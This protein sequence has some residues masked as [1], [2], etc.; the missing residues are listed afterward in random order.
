MVTFTL[1]GYLAGAAAVAWASGQ[2]LDS[3]TD[4]EWTDLTDA[5]D[6]STNKY[7]L[8]DL[9]L[10]LGSAAFAG[11]DSIIEAYLIASVDGTNYGDWTGNVTTNEQENQPYLVF[12]FTTSGATAAQRLIKKRVALPN[13]LY[14][15]GFR[16]KSGVTLAASGNTFKWR[17][18]SLDT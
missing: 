11:T 3:L 14:K 7:A 1:S 5:I 12:S 17:P 10:V 9:E 13:G 6:N 8:V 16:N 2:D 15:W 4:D 18:H